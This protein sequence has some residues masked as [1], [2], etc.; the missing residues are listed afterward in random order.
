MGWQVII[1][2]SAQ[3]DLAEIVRYENYGTRQAHCADSP[4]R[5]SV[6]VM[7]LA[8]LKAKPDAN[9]RAAVPR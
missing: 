4:V 1:A 5:V 6:L 3:T 2:P 8:E 7:R 9:T